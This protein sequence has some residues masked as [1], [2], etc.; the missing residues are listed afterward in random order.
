VRALVLRERGRVR[1][2]SRRGREATAEYPEVA[3]ALARLPGGD[4][5]VDG[6]IVALDDQ[7]RPSFHR[8]ARRMHRARGIAAA[9]AATPA[10]LYMYDCLALGGRDLRALPLLARKALLRE[11]APGRDTVRYGDHVEGDGQAFLEAACA[12]GLEGVVAK[13]ADAPYRGGRRLEWRKIKC[14]RR[15][16]FVIGG[17]TDPKGARTHL[18]ALHLGVHDDDGLLYVG[19]VGSGFDEATLRALHARLRRLAVGRCPF[20]RGVPPRGREHHWVRPELVCEV[21]FGEWTPDGSLRHP[22][23]L[24][25]RDDKRPEEVRREEPA[26]PRS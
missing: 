10:T 14:Q 24:G 8:L 3:A 25:L 6:E 21:R 4:L 26:T 23:F 22:I 11:L 5:A 15:Q 9:A 18:G 7:G 19:R 13:R 20:T 17:W 16:E 12:Q 2:W 1:L